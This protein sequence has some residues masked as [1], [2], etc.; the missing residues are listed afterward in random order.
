MRFTVAC[1][2][3]LT[4]SHVSAATVRILGTGILFVAGNNERNT[5]DLNGQFNDDPELGDGF[6]ITDSTGG[7]IVTQG[8]GCRASGTR[9]ICAIT[10][11]FVKLE[12]RDDSDTVVS[13]AGV[14]MIVNGGPG[15]DVITGDSED[16]DLDGDLGNDTIDGGRGDD[17]IRGGLGNDV[18]SGRLGKD[19]LIGGP[20]TDTLDGGPE[21]DD[22]DGGTGVDH[23]IGGD[24][25]D[26]FDAGA[27]DDT[28][29]ARDG[30]AETIR[31]GAGKETVTR[32]ANDDPRRCND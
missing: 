13:L 19:R 31:C 14:R 20:G 11:T 8:E 18:L 10:P 23:L 9:V 22:L 29:E 7:P 15:N 32:D 1:L 5:V 17:L 6:L 16:D 26:T 25:L 4:A 12:L 27:G 30:I 24:G 2:V 28:I 3:F 21:N